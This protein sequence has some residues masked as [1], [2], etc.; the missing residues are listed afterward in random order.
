MVPDPFAMP[1]SRRRFAAASFGAVAGAHVGTGAAA[2][3]VLDAAPPLA[4]GTLAEYAHAADEATRLEPLAD[5]V[6]GS[7]RWCTGRFVSQRWRDV[8]WTHE[9]SIV[10]PERVEPGA[11]TI[12][13]IDGGTSSRLPAEGL[14]GPTGAVATLAAVAAAAGLPAAVVRQVPYQPMFGGKVEDDLIAHTFEQFVRTGDETWPLLLPMVKS[15]VTAMTAIGSE[16]ARR[17]NHEIDRFVVTGAS[18]RGWTTWLSAA[19]DPRVTGLVPMVIDMLSMERHLELQEA[20]FGGF[21]DELVDYTSRGI[22]KLI[23]SPRGR[24]LV[25]IVDPFGYRDRIVQPKLIALGTNDPYWPLEA[26]DLYYGGLDGPRWVSYAP[27][28]GHDLPRERVL[29]LVAAMGRHAAG[30]ERLPDVSWEIE[31]AGAGA[32]IRATADTPP[33]EVVL[34]TANSATR[35]FRRAEWR[36]AA[37]ERDGDGWRATVAPPD[38]GFAAGFVEMRFD[39][40]P[41]PL[42]LTTGVR[43]VSA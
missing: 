33:A 34:W 19:V 38:D 20:T 3:A 12:L 32:A 22:Q 14:A 1:L 8:E 28:A 6:V 43:V 25:S 29:G 4:G 27:N 37:A 24:D 23:G 11:P 35:D 42:F 13:W 39:R 16:A 9:L 41:V 21:S 30:S 10:L 26:L 31:E 17:W 18:K 36:S 2:D 40:R 7:T 15:A 5:G